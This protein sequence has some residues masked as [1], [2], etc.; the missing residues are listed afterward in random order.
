MVFFD[1]GSFNTPITLEL[2]WDS[3]PFHKWDVRTILDVWLERSL[4]VGVR[5]KKLSADLNRSTF[6]CL[7]RC[8]QT[9]QSSC[10]TFA[11]DSAARLGS[12]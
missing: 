4:I 10:K 3:T 12:P 11:K 7:T 8:T 5:F 2:R 6:S 1:G 9:S